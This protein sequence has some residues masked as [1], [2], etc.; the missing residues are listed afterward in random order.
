MYSTYSNIGRFDIIEFCF[1]VRHYVRYMRLLSYIPSIIH[2]CIYSYLLNVPFN[3]SD[4]GTGIVY[5]WIGSKSD[6]EDARLVGEVA[7]E[8]FNNVSCKSFMFRS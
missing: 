4:E 8:M 5:A 2:L 1:L 7:E 6:P 3:N